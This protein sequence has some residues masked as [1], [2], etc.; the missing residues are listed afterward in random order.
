MNRIPDLHRKYYKTSRNYNYD[1]VEAKEKG[2]EG[3]LGIWDL[4]RKKKRGREVR[5]MGKGEKGLSRLDPKNQRYRLGHKMVIVRIAAYL[6]VMC[7]PIS[8][9]DS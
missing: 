9:L 6:C 3:I 2:R 1:K 5:G 4:R 7:K 8:D